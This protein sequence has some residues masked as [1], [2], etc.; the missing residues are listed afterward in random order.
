MYILDLRLY[1]GAA[2]SFLIAERK[3][4]ENRAELDIF[5]F[6]LFLRTLY[7]IKLNGDA[8]EEALRAKYILQASYNNYQNI[9]NLT[10]KFLI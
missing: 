6:I 2:L 5:V 4:F 10:L 3:E 1:P 7:Q 8:T 9:F